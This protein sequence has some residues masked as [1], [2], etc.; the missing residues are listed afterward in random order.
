MDIGRLTAAGVIGSIHF[1]VG[2]ATGWDRA[3]EL[4]MSPSSFRLHVARKILSQLPLHAL[5]RPITFTLPGDPRVWRIAAVKMVNARSG[6]A[7]AVISGVEPWR[8]T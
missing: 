7:H 4:F 6:E 2:A 8:P 1:D 5:E 3:R